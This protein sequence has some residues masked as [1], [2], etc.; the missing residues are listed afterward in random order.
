[1]S[2]FRE[3]ARFSQF[4]DLPLLICGASGTGKELV[5]RAIAGMDPKRHAGPFVA[6]NCAAVQPNLLES[7]FFGHRRGAFTGADRDRKGWIRS[8]EGGVLFLDEIGEL[9]LELQAKLL[10][11]VQEG[12]V[13][14]VGEEQEVAINVR[15]LAATN[16]DLDR[17][18]AEGRFREDLYHRLRALV[19]HLP[20]LRE[21]AA[22]LPL[23]VDHFLRKHAGDGQDHGP[24]PEVSADFL[25]AL[26]T[27][28][29]PGNLRQL[30]HLIQQSLLT[31]RWPGVLDLGDLP[32][33]MLRQ[34][35]ADPPEPTSASTPVENVSSAVEPLSLEALVPDSIQRVLSSPDWTLHRVLSECE[36]RVCEAALEQARG[37]QTEAAR[38]LGITSRSVYNKRRQHRLSV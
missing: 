16:R 26:G 34:L 3:A 35:S 17:L 15:F 21:R 27:L 19:V 29:L 22:D 9:E 11:V 13:R 18:V 10:R 7:E 32:A 12:C 24:F 23:L 37:N 4:S 36:R 8:A 6:I 25:A 20:P 5:A 33:E 38:L 14:A 1:V 28:D 31:R 2:A 30:D